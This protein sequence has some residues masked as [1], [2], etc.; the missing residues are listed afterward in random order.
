MTLRSDI[1]SAMDQAVSPA[2]WLAGDIGDSIRDTEMWKKERR[3]AKAK[4]FSGFRGFGA[5]AA[6]M[7]IILLVVGILVGGQLMPDW[8]SF[9]SQTSPASGI[10]PAQLAALRSRPVLLP[11]M[12]AVTRCEPRPLTTIGYLGVKRDV[13]G[14]GPVY[15]LGG[16]SS[17]TTTWGNYWDI[18]LLTSLSLKGPIL[19]R[20]E[21]LS[22]HAPIA[23]IALYATGQVLG[24]E[25]L[26][27]RTVERYA[28]LVLDASHPPSGR[29]DDGSLAAWIVRDAEPASSTNYCIGWQ[30]DGPTFTETI[31]FNAT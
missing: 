8:R 22:N 21:N 6:V 19:I 30:I 27:G 18:T 9:G 26:D 24:S 5:L 13:V 10:D 20:G 12:P 25:A 7:I 23:F 31:I 17:E 2:P 15:S 4:V 3:R 1:H 14:S 29:S 28:E 16:F 11:T